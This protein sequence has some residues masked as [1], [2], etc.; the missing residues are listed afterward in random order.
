MK[1]VHIVEDQE[2]EKE[3]GIRVGVPFKKPLFDG[4]P[5]HILKVPQ[6]LEELP[7]AG[8]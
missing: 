5:P 4:L 3:A 7:S 6:P 1:A 2:A 8:D